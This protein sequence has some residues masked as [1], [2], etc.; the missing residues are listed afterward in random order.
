MRPMKVFCRYSGRLPSHDHG[1]AKLGLSQMKTR[2]KSLEA[3][4][5]LLGLLVAQV[6]LWWRDEECCS[7]STGRVDFTGTR[8]R[9]WRTVRRL[10]DY[11]DQL[12]K[13][14]RFLFCHVLDIML[15]CL[16]ADG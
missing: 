8:C 1:R 10:P 9:N 4:L 3:F 16:L 6:E 14:A 12:E 15:A 11:L 5:T 13:D 7:E 2:L